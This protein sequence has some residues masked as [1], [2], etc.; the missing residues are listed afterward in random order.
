[1]CPELDVLDRWLSDD[2]DLEQQRELESHLSSC[3][4]C[5]LRIEELRDNLNIVSPMRDVLADAATSG[6]AAKTMPSTFEAPA[7][8]GDYRIVRELGR[9]GMGV[10]YEAEQRHPRRRVALKVIA[11]GR[12]TQ[13]A[14]RRFEF[15][16]SVLGRLQHPGIAQIFDAATAETASGPCPFFAMELIEGPSLLRFANEHA[17]TIRARLDLIARIADAVQYAHGRGVIHRDLKPGNILVVAHATESGTT[18]TT[19]IDD[20]TRGFAATPKIL[21][22]GVARVTDA[23]V[24]AS[25]LHTHAGQ[26]VGT[27]AYM[28]PEQAAG[29]A[30]DVDARADVYALGL[31]AFELLAGRTPFDFKGLAVPQVARLICESAPP[32]LASLRRDLR[33]DVSTIVG[34]ALEKDRDR[35]YASAGEMAQDIRRLLA[36]EPISARPPST[37]YSLGRFARRHAVVVSAAALVVAVSVAAAILAIASESRATHARNEAQNETRRARD[38][39][40]RATAALDDARDA[41]ELAEQRALEARQEAAKFEAVN[42][43]L[44]RMFSSVN[45]ETSPGNRDMKVRDVL[46]RAAVELDNGALGDQTVVE[47]VIRGQLGV[48]YLSL[49]MLPE[50]AAQLQRAQE[51]ADETFAVDDPF[52]IGLLHDQSLVAAE[53]GRFDV[54][55][56]L[57]REA[58]HIV[59][60][61][62]GA[63]DRRLPAMLNSLGGFLF[64]QGRLDEAESVLERARDG[65]RETDS[66]VAASTLNSLA[67][68]RHQRGDLPG[69]EALYR[70]SLEQMRARTD[71]DA[72]DQPHVLSGIGRVLMDQGRY[73]EAA[74]IV[75]EMLA[76]QRRLHG[77][78]HPGLVTGLNN[79][80]MMRRAQKRLDDAEAALREALD[81]C[82]ESLPPDH[83]DTAWTLNNL[84]LV[85]EDSGRM[86]AAE[87]YYR[88]A[89]DMYRKLLG[90]AHDHTLQSG[91]NFAALLERLRRYDDAEAIR[92]DLLETSRQ[93]NGAVHPTTLNEMHNLAGLYLAQSRIAEANALMAD[94]VDAAP[95]VLADTDWRTGVFLMRYGECRARSGDYDGGLY[96]LL[97]ARDRLEETVGANHLAFATCARMLK[98]LRREFPERT[99]T[100]VQDSDDDPR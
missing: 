13:A 11:P 14:L 63:T 100:T 21:D 78:A 60:R 10:V 39:E 75:E 52:L 72:H 76:M 38:A 50:A 87:S 15:E 48:T 18:G 73:D 69:A 98:Q 19:R 51:R 43:Y 90:P 81:L 53:N 23:D 5:Q 47:A 25:T 34:K 8:I 2:I 92:S 65:A 67:A 70:E 16:A 96:A 42:R 85:V 22:F 41:R 36:H 1:M 93:A 68:V 44:T 97:R 32:T 58:I 66:T 64:R 45:P 20:A 83:P 79:L 9:G 33:G 4:T 31:V 84:G 82:H 54:A 62:G 46:D 27:L 74:P 17:L 30:D 3:A 49:G 26:L 57:V 35:R 80:G 12:A 95:R 29:R 77:D 59:E 86:A 55:E 7:Q 40:A 61:P 88:D 28:S 91:R 37:L 6:D 56:A 89:L 94:V 71:G 99:S 24:Q